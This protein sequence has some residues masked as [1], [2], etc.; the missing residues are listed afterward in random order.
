M[1]NY[2]P[3]T[4]DIQAIKQLIISVNNGVNLGD[5]NEEDMERYRTVI[6]IY[7]EMIDM[8]NE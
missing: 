5:F 3:I 7:E 8:Q 4:T 6:M 2:F 1:D